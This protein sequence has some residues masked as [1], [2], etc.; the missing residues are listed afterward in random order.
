[1][2]N[3]I[4]VIILNIYRDLYL[5]STPKGNFD[6]LV[7]NASLNELDEKE[8]PYLDYEISLEKE[9]E[10]FDKHLK[11]KKLTKLTQQSIYNTVMLGCSP[12]TKI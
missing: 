6:E 2:N 12:K 7:E 11:N 5:N 4:D 3:K 8:I 9:K 1:M 10:I